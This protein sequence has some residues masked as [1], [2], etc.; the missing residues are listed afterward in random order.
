ML[1]KKSIHRSFWMAMALSLVWLAT[2][3]L[4]A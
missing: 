3:L 1:K 4:S 2:A